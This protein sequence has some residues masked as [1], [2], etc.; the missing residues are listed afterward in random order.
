[1]P[2]LQDAFLQAMRVRRSDI[3]GHDGDQMPFSEVEDAAIPQV[4]FLGS[5]YRRGGDILMGINPGGGGDTYRRTCEDNVLLPL[6]QLAR[7]GHGTQKDLNSVFETVSSNMQTWKLWRIVQPVLDA[8]GKGQSEVAY[9]NYCPFRTRGDKM[10]R[11]NAMR[12]CKR[13]LIDPLLTDL[14][15]RRVIALGKKAGTQLN[16]YAPELAEVITVPRTIG[17]SYI[18]A[19]AQLVLNELKDMR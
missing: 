13:L 11:A 17:D 4:G 19:E 8:I 14:A 2:P 3:F 16:K 18:S 10:P 1:M 15:P 6:I 12:N 9:L 5:E 7:S